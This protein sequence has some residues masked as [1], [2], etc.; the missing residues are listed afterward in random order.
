MTARLM[1][2]RDR[3]I[4]ELEN[5]PM[6]ARPAYNHNDL[7]VEWPDWRLRTVQSIRELSALLREEQEF[8]RRQAMPIM[9]ERPLE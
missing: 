5:E 8:E 2:L 6:D 7:R 4:L 9:L 3:W 1:A